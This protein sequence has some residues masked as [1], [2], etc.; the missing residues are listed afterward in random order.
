LRAASFRDRSVEQR[1]EQRG[2]ARLKVFFFCLFFGGATILSFALLVVLVRCARRDDDVARAKGP[3]A[4]RF[5]N[6]S[7]KD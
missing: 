1:A 5:F 3:Y 4:E 2:G 7:E 6:G